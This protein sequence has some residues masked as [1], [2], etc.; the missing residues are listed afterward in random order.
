MLKWYLNSLRCVYILT[1]LLVINLYWNIFY[2]WPPWVNPWLHVY[3][4][5]FLN[6]L[7]KKYFHKNLSKSYVWGCCLVQTVNQPFQKALSLRCPISSQLM[8]S[9]NINICHLNQ[10]HKLPGYSSLTFRKKIINKHLGKLVSPSE[11][12]CS[13]WPYI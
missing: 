4:I 7:G 11:W 5:L 2:F 6:S 3:Y 8:K 12:F 10:F 9:S 1:H 13:S